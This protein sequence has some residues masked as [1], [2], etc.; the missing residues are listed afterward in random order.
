MTVSTKCVKGGERE[1]GSGLCGSGVSTV[2]FSLVSNRANTFLIIYHHCNNSLP[3][4][5]P[6]DFKT[7]RN[8]GRVFSTFER[9]TVNMQW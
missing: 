1:C 4:G 5:N 8:F 7:Y 6:L 2:Y 3:H 9:V